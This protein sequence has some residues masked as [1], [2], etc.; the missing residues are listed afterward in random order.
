M[1]VELAGQEMT[2]LVR[3]LKHCSVRPRRTG[4]LIRCSWML[5]ACK[6]VCVRE[7]MRVCESRRTHTHTHILGALS[8]SRPISVSLPLCLSAYL[9]LPVCLSLSLCLSQPLPA[10]LTRTKAPRRHITEVTGAHSRVLCFSCLR[11]SCVA[12]ILRKRFACRSQ[13]LGHL[14]NHPLWPCNRNREKKKKKRVCLLVR[15]LPSM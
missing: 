13:R 9:C 11:R 7:R 4:A 1:S 2:G 14:G 6:G 10:H 5:E 8:L 12:C 15:T 3:Q